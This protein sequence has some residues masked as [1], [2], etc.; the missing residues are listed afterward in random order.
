MS[1]FVKRTPIAAL[2]TF[3]VAAVAMAPTILAVTLSLQ[4]LPTPT[5]LAASEPGIEHEDGAQIAR[6]VRDRPVELLVAFSSHFFFA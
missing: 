6:A 4:R 1:K 3:A 5:A 2:A